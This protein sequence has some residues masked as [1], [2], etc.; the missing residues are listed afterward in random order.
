MAGKSILKRL[1]MKQAMKENAPF[2]HEGIMSI[3]KSL[4]GNV[5]AQVKKWVKSAK[6]QGQDIDKMSEQ[7]LKYLIELNK[8]RAPTVLSNEEAYEFLNRFLNQNKR[9]EVIKA[10][11]GKPFKEEIGSV[12]NVV[13][14]ITRMEPIAAMKEVNKVLRREGKYKNLSKQDSEKVFNDTN[15]W[16]NQRDPSDLYDYKNKRPFRE[17]PNFDPDD[18]DFDPENFAGGG[19]AGMLG[20]P[21]YQDDNHRVP[22]GGGGAGKP[23]ITFTLQG[24]GSYGSNEIGPGLDLTQSGY[25]FDLGT[26]IDLPFG[27]SLTG[28]VGIGRGKGEVDYN[29]QNVFTGVDETKLG[30]KWNVGLKWSKKF[31]EGGRVPLAGGKTPM[32]SDAT[33]SELLD[34]NFDEGI[35]L[36][37]IL[38]LLRQSQ[39]G[40][41]GDFPSGYQSKWRKAEGGRVPFG[42]GGFE[43]ARRLFLKTMGA[44]VAGT[45]AAKSGLFGLLKGSKSAKVADLT[46]VPIHNAEGMPSWFKPLV[47]RVIKEGTETT[48]LPIHKGG[49]MSERE[50]VHSAKLGENQG[51]R[52]YQ[53]LDNQTITVEYQSVDN[54]GGV[55]DGI[56][57]LEYKAAEEVE[58]MLAR[59]MNPK[60]PKGEWLPNK[61]QKTK[62]TFEAN[63]AYPLQDPKDYKWVTF[64]DTN[65]VNK[66]D[67]LYSDTSPLKQFATGKNLSKKELAI[68]KQKRKQVK[69]IND[70]PAEELAGKEYVPDY[71]DFAS[72]GRVPFSKGKR[73]LQG[74]AKLMDEFF[75][76]TT[77]IGQRSKPYPEKVQEKMDL[78]K[79]FDDLT[80]KINT[81]EA[82]SKGSKKM[83]GPIKNVNKKSKVIDL[84]ETNRIVDDLGGDKADPFSKNFDWRAEMNLQTEIAFAQ[85]ANKLR[86]EFPG[87]SD[88]LIKNILADDNPQR[89]AEVKA[90]M[91]EA[92]KMQEKG[93]GVEEIIN[94]FKKKPTKHATGGIAGGRVGLLWGGGVWKTLIKNLAKERGVTPS[95]Y[96]KIT[97]Y[98]ALPNEVKKYISKAD[99]EKMKQG[100]IEMFEN[101]VEMAKTRK[102]FLE[103]IEQGKKTPAAPIFEH[104][105]KSFKSP[106]PPGVTDKDILQGEFILKNLKTKGR[107]LNASGGLAGMLG[108]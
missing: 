57:R 108:E 2:Q 30:D 8:P 29:D 25:G 96:L 89:I 21:T 70:D 14:D 75:P 35:D 24:G 55:D 6:R 85:E 97:N 92:M 47:N 71:D 66:V 22:Y 60:D 23:P 86:K 91:K 80:N 54:M 48:N 73:A 94:M 34:I 106:V 27:F 16:I 9:G 59:H 15:D 58:P 26:N 1:L 88:D 33:T 63:E 13:N 49:A 3:S 100:R 17:D 12:D 105:E 50:I 39:E 46:S 83:A 28:D 79:A 11:F 107:K 90:A 61:A 68:A 18:P 104:L 82:L 98:K 51:V 37:I 101:W 76:G 93:M 45:A 10:D 72:G 87:I 43:K 19:I 81:Q 52:V 32:P 67:D 65:V 77:K 69:K 62:S 84:D 53:N 95:N 31:N 102:A 56:V 41:Q 103:N 74:L 38:R 42:L 99:F 36:E 7:E 5:D 40:N 78:R 4:S 44:G 64:E 20:E